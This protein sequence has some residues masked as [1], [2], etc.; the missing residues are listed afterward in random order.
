MRTAR[1]E[2][3][4]ITSGRTRSDRFRFACVALC[5]P[6]HSRYV[7][8]AHRSSLTA[9]VPPSLS[10]SPS[11]CHRSLVTSP[12]AGDFLFRQMMELTLKEDK[13]I[14]ENIYP[15]YQKGFMNARY[16]QQVREKIAT[17][18]LIQIGCVD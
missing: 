3:S 6:H 12:Q 14:I 10:L 5:I 8:N 15:E 4:R 1:N 17:N 13:E 2:P 18:T 11:L 16:D 9:G 7:P